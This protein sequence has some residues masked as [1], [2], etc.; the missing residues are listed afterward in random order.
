MSQ[1]VLDLVP[2]WTLVLGVGVFLYVLAGR[3][4]SGRGHPLRVRAR[5]R[6][7]QSGHELDRADLGRQR[8][9]ARSRRA[10]AHGGLP[11]RLRDHHTGGLFSDPHHAA[12]ARLSRRRVRVPLPRRRASD[13]L[14]SRLQLRLRRRRL[15]PGHRARRVHSGLPDR[16]PPLRR[17]LV[18]LLHAVL[19]A[20]RRRPRLRLQPARRGLADPENR[21]SAS[22]LGADAGT[23]V[24]SAAS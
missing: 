15:R 16:W 14:G 9:L 2:I 4:R 23:A 8:D 21:R 20:H 3:L 11:A 22:G 19:A 13:L 17:R 18:R 10:C 7:A 24:R 12:G 5:P 1:P 6:F